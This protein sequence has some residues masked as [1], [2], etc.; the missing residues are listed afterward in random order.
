MR[1]IKIPITCLLIALLPALAWGF[2]PLSDKELNAV[3][4]GSANTNQESQEA[5][6]RIPFHYSSKKAQV[7]GEV[8]V[9][10]MTTYNQTA[11]L[12]LMDNA[13]SNLSSLI[14][15]NAVSSPINI[16]MNLNI[17]VNSTIGNL[18]QLNTLI[19]K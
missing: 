18:N 15:I 5:L 3:T 11:T 4:A 1:I 14:N 13:Q 8:I 2:E 9:L 7:D 19:A 17:S 16:L 12:Q 10:P 6:S